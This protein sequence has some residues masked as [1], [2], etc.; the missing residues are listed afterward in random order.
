MYG[1]EEGEDQ[2]RVF[3]RTHE[4]F[5]STIHLV[6]SKGGVELLSS[7]SESEDSLPF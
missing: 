4:C 7:G 2:S 3:M 5:T 6:N 1:S